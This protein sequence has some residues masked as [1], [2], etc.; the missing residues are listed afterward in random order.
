MTSDKSSTDRIV[1][2]LSRRDLFRTV[3]LATGGAMLLGLPTFLGGWASEAEAACAPGLASL[4]L[5]G[6]F[7]C[8]L[9]SVDGGNAFADVVPEAVGPDMIQRKRPGPVRFEDIMIRIALAGVATPLSNW[10]TDMLVKS[11]APKNGAIVYADPSYNEVKRLEFFNAML[12]EVT[13]LP[14]DAKAGLSPALL[15]LR[16]TP[17]T[18]RLTGSTGKKL[19][20]TLG[21][22]TPKSLRS[23]NFRFNVQGLEKACKGVSKVDSIVARR[24]FTVPIPGQDKFLQP[25]LDCSIVRIT[26]PETDAGPFYTWFDESVVKGKTAGERA[27]VLEWLDPIM[28]TVLGS[29]QLGGLGIVRYAPEPI[30]AGSDK[31][32]GLVQVDMYCETINL[33]I[34]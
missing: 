14:A 15:I 16:I 3:G 2:D 7:V 6:I 19:T 28:T 22:S 20:S 23:S 25:A 32:I 9:N 34:L 1:P 31:P 26:L 5:D 10:I 27:G 8:S 12:T 17:Q 18:T 4:E 11:P 33:T 21:G 24:P 29:L 30:S 13:V